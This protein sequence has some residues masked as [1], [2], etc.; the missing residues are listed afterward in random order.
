[1]SLGLSAIRKIVVDRCEIGYNLTDDECG[2]PLIVESDIEDKGDGLFIA[3]FRLPV[4]KRG[5]L[6][7]VAKL[8]CGDVGC[9]L[10]LYV[11]EKRE[12]N[13]PYLD[14]AWVIVPDELPDGPTE[15]EQERV[16]P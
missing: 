6:E 9:D 8:V 15:E 10:H 13:L 16:L 3:R 2:F 14:C 4:E 5:A 12:Y 1:M 7:R 11:T